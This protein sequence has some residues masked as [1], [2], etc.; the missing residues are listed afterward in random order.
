MQ[1]RIS[2]CLFF[3]CLGFSSH[4]RFFLLMFRS[5]HY[6][7]KAA[8]FDICSVPNA[9][10]QWGF[11]SVP[12][13]LW[14]ETSVYNGHLRGP[15]TL[16]PNA[17]YWAVELSLPVFITKVCRGWD[18][19]TQPSPCEANALTYGATAAVAIR[20]LIILRLSWH[21]FNWLKHNNN[22]TIWTIWRV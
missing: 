11:L 1:L 18:V 14:H 5:H 13:L 6:R 20:I 17:K 3:V 10:A 21:V 16:T 8:N 9:I 22:I 15:I 12:Q 7:W 2:V 4:L 19:N